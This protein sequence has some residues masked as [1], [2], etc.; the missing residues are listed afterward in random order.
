METELAMSGI[1]LIG[2]VHE[3]SCRACGPQGL[4]SIT[5]HLSRDVKKAPS[6]LTAERCFISSYEPDHPLLA[7]GFSPHVAHCEWCCMHLCGD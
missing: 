5:R 4:S 2:V 1:S 7:C 3:G 6:L